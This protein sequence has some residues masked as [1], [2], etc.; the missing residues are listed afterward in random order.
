MFFLENALNF[1]HISEMHQKIQK[2][3]FASEKISFEI[4]AEILHIA[5]GILVI[6]S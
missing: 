2:K 5:A 1:M 4:V 3:S 6:G